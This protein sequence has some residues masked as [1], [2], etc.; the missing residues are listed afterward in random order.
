MDEE[1]TTSLI[2]EGFIATLSLAIESD[3]T[4]WKLILK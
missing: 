1:G 2:D 4:I 3:K